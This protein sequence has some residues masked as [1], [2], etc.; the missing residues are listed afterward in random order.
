MHYCVNSGEGSGIKA[1]AMNLTINHLPENWEYKNRKAL[2]KW[3]KRLYKWKINQELEQKKQWK[4]KEL[5]EC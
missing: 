2:F 4:L 5:G 1:E 3:R